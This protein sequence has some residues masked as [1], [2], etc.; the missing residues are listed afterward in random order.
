MGAYV[1]DA[2]SMG[3]R[4]AFWGRGCLAALIN[5]HELPRRRK[6]RILPVRKSVYAGGQDLSRRGWEHR[7]KGGVMSLWRPLLAVLRLMTHCHSLLAL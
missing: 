2:P 7:A 3:L 6:W 1:K 4:R 5:K